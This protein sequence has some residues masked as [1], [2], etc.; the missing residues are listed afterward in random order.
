MSS[1]DNDGDFPSGFFNFDLCPGDPSQQGFPN[2]VNFFAFIVWCESLTFDVVVS[3][4]EPG[5]GG[6]QNY[7]IQMAMFANCGSG[8]SGWDPVNCITNGNETWRDSI[9]LHVIYK[10]SIFI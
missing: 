1:V 9:F 10:Q 7:G 3:N 8:N 4:C 6:G 5:S 2:N